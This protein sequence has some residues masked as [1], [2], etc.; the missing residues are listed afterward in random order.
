MSN[1]TVPPVKETS[2]L[3]DFFDFKLMVFPVI[4]KIIYILGLISFT[5]GAG[6]AIIDWRGDDNVAYLLLLIPLVPIYAI[7]SHLL[8]EFAVV[9]FSILN[10]L[11]EIRDMMAGNMAANRQYMVAMNQNNGAAPYSP[12]PMQ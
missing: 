11:R 12:T 6:K 3:N 8:L 2:K 5:I 1:Q 10:V 9:M 7:V 4:V